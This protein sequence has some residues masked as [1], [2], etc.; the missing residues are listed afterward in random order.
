M[1]KYIVTTGQNIYDVALHLT[2]SIEGIIDLMLSN[3]TLSRMIP[4]I[5]VTS[6]PI[7]TVL[8][9]MRRWWRNTAVTE[10]SRQAGNAGFTPNTLQDVSACS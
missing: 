7:R 6:F 2:G 4:C 5:A 1:G 3:P 9:S 8:L 10:L